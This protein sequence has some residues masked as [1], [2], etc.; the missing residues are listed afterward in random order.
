MIERVRE[1]GVPRTAE[2]AAIDKA[3]KKEREELDLE[4]SLPSYESATGFAL[5]VC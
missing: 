3:L 1:R 2:E 4:A 5:A